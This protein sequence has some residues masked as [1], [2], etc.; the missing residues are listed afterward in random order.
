MS[1]TLVP[2]FNGIRAALRELAP[3]RLSGALHVDFDP[4]VRL[5]LLN[6]SVYFAEVDKQPDLGDRLVADALLSQQQLDQGSLLVQGRRH[7]GRLFDWTEDVDRAKVMQAIGSYSSDVLSAAMRLENVRV[8]FLP[9]QHH[10]SGIVSWWSHELHQ[11]KSPKL[12]ARVKPHQVVAP[13]IDNIETVSVAPL[14]LSLLSQA[15]DGLRR[16]VNFGTQENLSGAGFEGTERPADSHRNFFSPQSEQSLPAPPSIPQPSVRRFAI[17]R[18]I[19][20]VRRL[21][22]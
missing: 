11:S 4:G 22:K 15:I 2:S 14:N 16:D 19:E 10:R 8:D 13:T 6:G 21:G 1:D 5:Y 12:V 9:N 17:S 20:G 3:D 18:L 7:L